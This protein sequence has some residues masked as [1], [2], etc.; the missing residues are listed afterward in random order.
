[1][2][3]QAA[4]WDAALR[5]LPPD[6]LPLGALHAWLPRSASGAAVLR[7]VPLGDALLD[8][9]PHEDDRACGGGDGQTL[10]VPNEKA[11]TG[12]QVPVSAGK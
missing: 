10:A 1:M 2:P 9:A 11:P 5:A 12:M 7:A 6:V 4:L 8:A 3:A